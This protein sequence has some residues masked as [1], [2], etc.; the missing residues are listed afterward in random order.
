MPF[1]RDIHVSDRGFEKKKAI[2]GTLPPVKMYN[3]SYYMAVTN[4]KI[5][6][7]YI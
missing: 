4:C 2:C 3:A 5:D 7:I 1:G 6:S